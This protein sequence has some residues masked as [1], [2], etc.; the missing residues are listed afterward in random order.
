MNRHL[1]ND[2]DNKK[3]IG[4]CG[5]TNSGKDA[6]ASVLRERHGWDTMAMADPM[7]EM[8]I[9]IDPI[10]HDPP[11]WL[12]D[13]SSPL[14]NLEAWKRRGLFSVRQK[15]QNLGQVMRDEN[16]GYWVS[17]MI[18]RI[19]A[20]EGPTIVTDLRYA[21]EAAMIDILGGTIVHVDREGCGPINDHPSEEG[22]AICIERANFTLTNNKDIEH[23]VAQFLTCV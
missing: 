19:E 5:W 8:L 18:P 20:S 13:N 4:L 10:F 11:M 12:H 15:L 2:K 9:A 21:N 23:L 22:T 3:L 17:K 16:P 14:E 7:K 6:M 1:M